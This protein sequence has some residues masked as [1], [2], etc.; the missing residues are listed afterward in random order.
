MGRV[1]TL[2]VA[3]FAAFSATGCTTAFTQEA[4]RGMV[5]YCPGAGNW[6]L[7]DSG[8]RDGLTRAGF[9]GQVAS[10]SWTVLANPA[11]DQTLRINARLAGTQVARALEQFIDT[12]PGQPV[13]LIGLSAGTGVAMW[14]LEDMKPGYQ[15]DNVVLLASSLSHKFDAGPAARA[16]R[17]KIYVYYS[18]NDAVLA[19][20]MKAF[21][22]IDGAYG[23][24][25]IGAGETGL[26]SPRAK[27][28]IVN[29]AYKNAYAKYGYFGGHTDGLAAPF[30]QA[31]LAKHL[32]RETGEGPTNKPSTEVARQESKSAPVETRG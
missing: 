19:G 3:A 5:F 10:V 4:A 26:Q 23:P 16:V 27:E 25:A 6:D 21:G 30:V 17:G 13:S 22:T 7:G 14:A 2:I 12:Y 18:S 32:I 31:V 1:C 29:I 11:I 28:K 15:V 24:F 9:K 8:L 20:P